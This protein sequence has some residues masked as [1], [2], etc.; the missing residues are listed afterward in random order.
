MHRTIVGVA[1]L[2]AAILGVAACGGGDDDKSSGDSG[3]G[4]TSLT[5][6]S[7]LPLQGDSRPQS[8]DVVKGEQMALSEAGNKVA[9]DRR[10]DDRRK[11]P[12]FTWQMADF[13]VAESDANKK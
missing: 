7:S 11:E 12:A 2:L 9:L 3:G 5:I 13:V 1:A 6:Y 10:Q 8:E 4:R